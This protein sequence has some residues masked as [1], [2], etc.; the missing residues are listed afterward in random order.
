MT[1]ESAA[2]RRLRNYWKLEAAN[3]V[4][5]PLVALYLVRNSGG[6]V[7]VPLLL[8]IAA[9]SFLLGIGALTL[10]MMYRS[11]CGRAD[12]TGVLPV[13]IG[14]RWPAIGLC[15]AAAVAVGIEWV[16]DGPV[17]SARFVATNILF[18]LAVIEYVNFYHVQIQHF[19]HAAD[20]KRLVSGRGFRRSYLARA[21][22]RHRREARPKPSS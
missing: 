13:L 1:A 15:V 7:T 17:L 5:V 9:F 22:E 4:L 2:A 3:A 12:A 21:I 14:L 19:D 6:A 8:S 18:L 16:N 10:R 11:A 20:W